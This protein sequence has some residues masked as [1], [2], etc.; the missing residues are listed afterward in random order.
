ML[1]KASVLPIAFL[2]GLS[3]GLEG[4]SG[5]VRRVVATWAVATARFAAHHGAESLDGGI[6]GDPEQIGTPGA[7]F[8]YSGSQNAFETHRSTLKVLGEDATYYGT[9]AGLASVYYMAILGLSYEIWI[10]YLNTLALVGVENVEAMTFAPSASG[11]STLRSAAP[12]A[13]P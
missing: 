8:Y 9:D 4:V 6:L 11:S 5:G 12:M 1:R 2:S 10:D 3:G 7:R 13:L